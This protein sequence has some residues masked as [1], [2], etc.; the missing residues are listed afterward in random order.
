MA[1]RVKGRRWQG[2]DLSENAD[3]SLAVFPAGFRVGFEQA[4]CFPSWFAAAF[5]PQFLNAG[6]LAALKILCASFTVLFEHSLILAPAENAFPE[7]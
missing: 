5:Y 1:G 2:R 6:S 7:K 3:L 4:L